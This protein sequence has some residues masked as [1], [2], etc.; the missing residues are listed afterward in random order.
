MYRLY[1]VCRTVH[2]V[3]F[4]VIVCVT[5][6]IPKSYCPVILKPGYCSPSLATL[7]KISV[8]M[9]VHIVY[10]LFIYSITSHMDR[11]TNVFEKIYIN[12]LKKV[13]YYN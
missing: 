12:N 13:K 7:V 8:R 4:C 1:V 6:S 11:F 10:N 5:A 3:W 2:V 9:R